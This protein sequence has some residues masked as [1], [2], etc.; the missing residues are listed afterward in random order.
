MMEL[1]KQLPHI[2]PYGNPQYFLYVITAILP[3]FIGLF[4]YHVDGCQDQSIGCLWDISNL[5]N[6]VGSFLQ[7]VSKRSRR[8]MDFLSSK[9]IIIAS[10]HLCQG[11]TSY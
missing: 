3:I 6:L 5:A 10:H 1:L 4:R 11:A 9:S 8:E 2:E 7:A